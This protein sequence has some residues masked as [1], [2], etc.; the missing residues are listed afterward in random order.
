MIHSRMYRLYYPLK[1]RNDLE[2][3]DAKERMLLANWINN[4][5]YEMISFPHKRWKNGFHW[6]F[7]LLDQLSH[8]EFEN[9]KEKLASQGSFDVRE[10]ETM[11]Q[12]LNVVL[13]RHK[14]NAFLSYFICPRNRS[15]ET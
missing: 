11:L 9:F 3:M 1:C 4:F 6:C 14:Y 13:Y 15:L 8:T 10:M 5:Y 2:M 7:P 12:I